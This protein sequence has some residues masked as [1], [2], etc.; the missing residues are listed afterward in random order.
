MSFRFSSGSAP[1]NHDPSSVNSPCVTPPVY[2]AMADVRGVHLMMSEGHR[3]ILFGGRSMHEGRWP[4][5]R[6]ADHQDFRQELAVPD[7]SRVGHAKVHEQVVRVLVVD[8]RRLLVGFTCLEDLRR[9]Q[10]LNR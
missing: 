6:A 8:E 10:G 5:C 2:D 3:R 9:A 1:R 7:R 4:Q